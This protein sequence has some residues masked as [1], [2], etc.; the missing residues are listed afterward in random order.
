MAIEWKDGLAI[1]VK[2]VDDQHKELFEK[3]NDLFNACNAGKGKEY[4]DNVIKY[5]Q[6]YVVL[7]FSSEEKLQ[8]QNNYP[9]YEGHKAQHEQFI[10]DFLALKEKIE[11]NG[12]TGLTIVQ[13]NQV[14]VDWLINHIRKT[15]K[16][17]G[18][19]LKEKGITI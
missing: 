19:Y 9:E 7:H 2:E 5:L 17:F 8:K 14:L 15:D 11:K 3:V 16:A 6:D 12:V 18:V 13:L 1:G 4:I 10:R